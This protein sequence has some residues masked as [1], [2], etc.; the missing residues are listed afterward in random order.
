MIVV[1]LDDQG[2]PTP[3]ALDLIRATWPGRSTG[4]YRADCGCVV[5]TPEPLGDLDAHITF[6]RTCPTGQHPDCPPQPAKGQTALISITAKTEFGED[7]YTLDVHCRCSLCGWEAPVAAGGR[8]TRK[9]T[10]GNL[11][12][13]A[14]AVLA[15]HHAERSPD[16]T[17]FPIRAAGGE[18]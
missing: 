15:L 17:G 3:E 2:V 4:I 8:M 1:H 16:C 11:L 14:M 13:L 9:R 7:G 12:E 10:L 5:A 18:A 6:F